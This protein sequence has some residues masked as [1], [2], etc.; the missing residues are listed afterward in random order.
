[1]PAD[2][3]GGNLRV[4]AA[5]LRALSRV[6]KDILFVGAVSHL[7]PLRALLAGRERRLPSCRWNELV[8]NF[9]SAPLTENQLPLVLREMPRLAWLFEN[10]RAGH[11]PETRFP[12]LGA[13]RQILRMA[14]AQYE[15]EYDEPISM[16]EWRALFQFGRNLA[17]VRGHLR[18]RLYEMVQAAKGCVDDDFGAIVLETLSHYPPNARP[19]EEQEHDGQHTSL[20]LHTEFSDG[21]ERPIHAYP[22]PP[23]GEIFFE[24]HRRPPATP[25]EKLKWR[26]GF[27]RNLMLGAG[28][29]SW[30]P[31]DIFIENFFRT[32]RTRAQ[33]E[34]GANHSTSEPFTSSV[35][36]GLDI[37][38]TMRH[39]HE[40]KIYVR[41]ERIPPGK[42][43]P[44]VLIWRD[45]HLAASNL[46][47]TSLYAENSNESD[48]AFYST[49]LG[50]EMVGPGISRIE[51]SGIL[52]VYPARG[53]ADVW[54]FPPLYGWETHGRLLVAAAIMMSEERYIAVVSAK[55]PHPE[56]RELARRH[57]R[58]LV[59]LPLAMFSRA[60]LKRA[61]K[62]HILDS[63]QARTW[64]SDYI[65]RV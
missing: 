13:L 24:F 27:G 20:N 47:R 7:V 65:P 38:E 57:S 33:Q 49:P 46:W 32:I 53:I 9:Q 59:Y 43:G 39:L 15:E 60:L 18:P 35:L 42:V 36:D 31:E 50:R 8:P 37:R 16:T 26:A 30:P 51:Y 14:S 19:G 41:R 40:R 34:I 61:R 22:Y 56:L 17:I 25:E 55:P 63:K 12:I 10:F 54:D 23:L 52:S 3:A 4:V 62:C 64:A 45:V 58:A 2:D 11:G 6:G 29:C 44:V 28:I 48:I 21:V 1:M 5:R